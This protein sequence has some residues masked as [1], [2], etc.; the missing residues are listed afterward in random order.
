M[1]EAIG[2]VARSQVKVRDDCDLHDVPWSLRREL[3]QGHVAHAR[4]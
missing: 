1:A 3:A 2:G 4:A